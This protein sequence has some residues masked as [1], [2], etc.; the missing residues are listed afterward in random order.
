MDGGAGPAMVRY[1]PGVAI[2][3]LSLRERKCVSRSERTT[4]GCPRAGRLDNRCMDATAQLEARS[5][6]PCPR[7]FEHLPLAKWGFRELNLFG[8][9]LF[10][11]T[12][13]VLLAPP[14]WRWLTVVPAV[15]LFF[16]FYFFR[17]PRRV[18]PEG[19]N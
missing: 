12:V 13:L 18:V 3:D 14:P 17:D 4:L 11:V 10:I 19:P 7:W 1:L 6:R 8:W 16:V 9:P 2:V 5:F 15:A